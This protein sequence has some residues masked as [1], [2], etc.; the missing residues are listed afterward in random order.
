MREQAASG[1][2]R[3]RKQD[4]DRVQQIAWEQEP[5]I[6]LVNKDALVAIAPVVKNAEPSVFRPQT[7]WNVETLAL[8]QAR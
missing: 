3:K 1:D 4:W 7:F 5:F 2:E 8:S 6:Y